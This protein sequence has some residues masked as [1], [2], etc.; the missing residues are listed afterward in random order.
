MILSGKNVADDIT[1]RN[2]AKA[3]ELRDKGINPTLAVIRVGENPSD[4]AYEK[5]LHKRAESTGVN[6]EG[7]VYDIDVTQEKLLEDIEKINKDSNI[8]GILVFRPLPSHIDDETICNAIDYRKDIDG[9][10]KVSMVGVYSGSNGFFPPCTAQACIE[11]LDYYDI[12]LAGKRVCV[13]GRSLVVGRP[14]AMMC[15]S[16]NAT[17]SIL[18]SRTR[19][20]DFNEAIRNAEIVI[21]A[22]G[23]PAM[24][25]SDQLGKDQIILDV[26]TNVDDEG[27][28]CGD[29][30]FEEAQQVATA[31]TP[32]PGGIGRITTAVLMKHVILA[33]SESEH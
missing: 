22:I 13:A 2:V 4:V 28:L 17:V 32:V 16:R 15:M 30:N 29:V 20:E 8:H 12:S 6:V 7:F 14:V 10:S 3:K 31:V 23:R 19:R 18:H 26:G 9:V 33:A 27:K 24:I 25:G 11:M 21:A 1:S 5:G